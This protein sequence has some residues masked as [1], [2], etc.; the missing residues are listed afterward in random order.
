MTTDA[1]TQA[2]DF[3]VSCVYKRMYVDCMARI[4]ALQVIILLPRSFTE[5][6]LEQ[7]SKRGNFIILILKAGKPR[8]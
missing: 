4:P 5:L 1:Y 7:I 6:I 2:S 3:S 8:T